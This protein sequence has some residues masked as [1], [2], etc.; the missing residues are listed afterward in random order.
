MDELTLTK[1]REL[2][3]KIK[4]NAQIAQGAL[5]EMCKGLAE[6]R[7][8]KL[9][10]QLGYN[11]FEDYTEKEISM[12]RKQAYHYISVFENLGENVTSRLQI[13]PHQ[14]G[15]AFS[16]FRRFGNYTSSKSYSFCRHSAH[17]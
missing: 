12:T 14:N 8:S 9:Y 16:F 5:W 10:K 2:D 13:Q 15:G 6:M 7:D 4:S 17:I 1:A 11:S 3:L